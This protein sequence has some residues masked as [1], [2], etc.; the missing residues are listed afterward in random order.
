[1]YNPDVSALPRRDLRIRQRACSQNRGRAQRGFSLMELM[2]GL[3]IG[4]LVVVAAIGSLVYTQTSST[5]V[6][7]SSRLQQTADAVFRNV[8]FHIAQASAIELD[9]SAADPAKVV[10]SNAYKGYDA[11][12]PYGIHGDEGSSGAP[13]TLRV[14]YQDGGTSVDCLGARPTPIPSTANVNTMF[15]RSSTSD[16]LMCLGWSNANSQP[17]ASGIRDFQVWYGVRTGI[18]PGAET[19]QFYTAN[20]LSAPPTAPNW[21][22]VRTVRIC[23]EVVGENANNANPSMTNCQGTTV[24][25]TDRLLHRVFWRTFTLRNTL[26]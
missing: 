6:G 4:L 18:V 7:D 12:R 9:T 1:M 17:V 19:F 14:S 26:L 15:S 11:T 8:G 3:T 16:D 24:T 2:V 10:F 22:A 25:P 23:I 21:T 13:D 5:V 20:Q